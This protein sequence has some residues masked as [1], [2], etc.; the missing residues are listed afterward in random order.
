M[1]RLEL[2]S[3]LTMSVIPASASMVTPDTTVQYSVEKHQ[4]H[5]KLL[6][7]PNIHSV[8]STRQLTLEGSV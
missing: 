7:S 3:A 1:G 6:C 4:L 8:W 5:Y 2:A